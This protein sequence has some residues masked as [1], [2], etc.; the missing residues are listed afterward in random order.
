MNTKIR[1]Q[2]LAFLWFGAVLAVAI[3]WFFWPALSGLFNRL[4]ADE[5]Y[6]Y[7]LI[8]PVVSGYIVY[9]KWP[10]LRQAT[11]Q[12][13]WV[14]LPVMAIGFIVYFLSKMIADRYFPPLT[15]LIILV[16]LVL[17]LGGWAILRLL[18]F[19]LLLLFLMIPLPSLIGGQLTFPLQL[20]SSFIA[21]QILRLLGI[22]VLL[23]G[24]VIDLGT[25]QL[26]IVAA[27]S[28]LRYILSL[29]ALGII[30]C[31]FYQRQVWKAA[32]LIVALIPAAIVANALRV[33]LMGLYPALMVGFPHIF[34]GWLIFVFSFA[35]LLLLNIIL[36]RWS[37]VAEALPNQ[38]TQIKTAAIDKEPRR[39]FVA[40]LIAATLLLVTVTCLDY[41]GGNIPPFPLRQ[42][43]DHFPLTLG[44]WTGKRNYIDSEIFEKIEATTYFDASFQ[45]PDTPPVS[46]YI[47]YYAKHELYNALVHTPKICMKGAGWEILKSGTVSINP[48]L[49]VSYILMDR[50][51]NKILTYYWHIQQGK[52]LSFKNLEDEFQLQRFYMLYSGLTKGRTD[53]AMVRLITPVLNDD[54]AA[55]N[56]RLQE[57]SSLVASRLKE[58]IVEK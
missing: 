34:T 11:W 40:P 33:S 54:L 19:P 49:S 9:L 41:S 10:Q 47:V 53:W 39:P 57:L 42:S 18:A 23:E 44:T 8:L 37:P 13:S 15:C 36:N 35:C 52:N 58:F 51:G 21:A 26:Q 48:N 25:R 7:G 31:Y 55:A 2:S 43:F 30:Y 20:T 1:S 6:S 24:N 29:L 50:L 17:L 14:G 3:I 38:D 56:Q 28:G 12:P 4:I 16:G 32:I 22:P 45:R 27:C 46:L 5:D